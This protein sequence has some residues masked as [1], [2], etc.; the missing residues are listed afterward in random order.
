VVCEP[1]LLRTTPG[2]GKRVR[3]LRVNIDLTV[4]VLIT[5]L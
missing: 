4:G 2:A 5:I 3:D 1:L